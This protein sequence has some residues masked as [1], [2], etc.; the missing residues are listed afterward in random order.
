MTLIVQQARALHSRK[1]I[2][3]QLA[4]ISPA[5]HGIHDD[6]RVQKI[7]GH[8]RPL[9]SRSSF[10]S[11]AP[12]CFDPRPSPVF[13]FRVVL[14]FADWLWVF[15]ES[16]KPLAFDLFPRGLFEKTAIWATESPTCASAMAELLVEAR[17]RPI[18]ELPVLLHRP[19]QQ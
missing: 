7:D 16:Q 1:K 3:Q 5:V 18:V 2:G 14:N 12:H 10:S 9:R 15:E 13:Q 8:Q 19:Q 17:R 11:S 6:G 4:A